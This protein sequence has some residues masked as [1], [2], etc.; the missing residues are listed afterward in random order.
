MK[1]R[2]SIFLLSL[3]VCA[4][5]LRSE[6]CSLD[7]V[8][9]ATLLLPYFDVDLSDPQGRT[10]LMSIGNATDR[11][12]LAH[13]T[14]WTDAGLP[15][16]N[17][18]VYLTGYDIQTLNLRDL[19]QGRLPATAD[20]SRDPADVLSPR[21]A[22]SQDTGFPQ[23][24]GLLPLPAVPPNIVDFFQKAHLGQPSSLHGGL[25]LGF[26]TDGKRARGYVTVDVV[27]RCSL[28]FPTDPGYFGPDG[29]AGH[30]NVL[31]GE[32]FYVEPG[33]QYA[34]GENL[35]RIESDP[36]RFKNGD[37]T[38][39]GRYVGDSGIDGREP[40]PRKWGVRYLTGGVFTAGTDVLVW[41]QPR[42]HPSLEVQDRPFRCDG[43]K[44]AW[45]PQI[46]DAFYVFD[47]EERVENS[48]FFI[49][50]PPRRTHPFAIA[51]R[52]SA[53][54]DLAVPF[55]FGWMFVDF[56][57][58]PQAWVGSVTSASGTFSGGFEGTPFQGSCAPPDP[59]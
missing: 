50:P 54:R 33:E 39:Y 43:G 1:R 53:L 4:G 45:Y 46:Q 3:V 34:Q 19:L 21:G 10:T 31:W 32:F 40:L 23:C 57:P 25:C 22:E 7:T 59:Q 20:P 24:E 58:S 55:D 52:Y 51:G 16:L 2:C 56:Q 30:D 12:T 42:R 27:R 38:F 49:T 36:S 15:T 6:I 18:N 37:R 28:L 48:G 17:F 9:A 44:P 8:P 26:P 14:L 35:V 5:V 13:V 11:A 41:A 29:V 47:E